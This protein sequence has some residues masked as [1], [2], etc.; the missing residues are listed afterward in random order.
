VIVQLSFAIRHTLPIVSILLF[1][2]VSFN[3]YRYNH[4]GLSIAHAQEKVTSKDIETNVADNKIFENFAKQ[5]GNIARQF[6]YTV[7]L[8]GK[9]I[10]PNDTLKQDIITH[11]KHSTYNISSLKYRLLGFDISASDIKIDVK[12]SRID[13]T[14]TKVDLP[15]VLA[16]N[17]T[18]T[19]GLLT[20]K[21][22]E[23]N[24]GSIYGIY[25]KNSDKMTLHIPINIAMQYLPRSP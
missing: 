5:F 3:Y 20:L 7:D 9:Q 10:F 16:R 2:I 24:L 4:Q 21:Y 11:Y 14:R 18:V 25:D 13:A 6:A 23:I 15:L 8:G 19:N 1:L 17:V 22:R 12:P